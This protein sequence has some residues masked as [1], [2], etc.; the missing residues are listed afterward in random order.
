MN[1]LFN[2]LNEVSGFGRVAIWAWILVFLRVGAVM[3]FV[4]AFGEQIIPP[5]VR[6]GLAFAFSAVIAPAVSPSI[7]AYDGA[8]YLPMAVEILAGLTLGIG[9]RLFVIALQIAATIIAQAT[10]LAQLF[11]GATPDPQ[12]AV[13]NLLTIAG[14]ALA[15]SAD[16]HVKVAEA[17]ILSYE[18]FPVTRFPPPSDMAD[19]GVFHIGRA[20]GLGFTLAAPFLIGSLV[21]NVALGVINRAMPQLMVAFVGAPALTLGGLALIALV[22]PLALALWLNAF[23]GFLSNPFQMAP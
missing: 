2:L 9:L 18:F 14:L 20:F 6:L 19:W 15:V 16:L 12:P 5:R 7:G 8:L 23:G 13:G 1:E 21:Y 3:A 17:L 22:L 10:S 4:P 11:G